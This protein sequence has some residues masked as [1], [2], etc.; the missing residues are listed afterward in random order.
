M[1][2]PMVTV[3]LPTFNRANLVE[4]SILSV[5]SQKYQD[6]ELIIVDDCSTD[7]TERMINKYL[8]SK[9]KCIKHKVNKGVSAARNTGLRNSS[10][11]KYVAFIDD[12]DEWL[13]EKL[14]KQIRLIEKNDVQLGAVGC[15][16]TDICDKEKETIIPKHRGWVFDQLLSR[17]AKGYG[18]PLLLVNRDL[19]RDMF[20]D[21]ELMCLEDNDF[22]MAIAKK[23]QVDFV[24]EPLVTVHR[25][26]YTGKHLWNSENALA[27]YQAMLKK[28]RSELNKNPQSRRFLLFL[29]SPRI[30]IFE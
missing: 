20:F 14:G 4:R 19:T 16:R 17:S 13:P 5:I 26:K 23:Y 9:I 25:G 8:S 24:P 6:W 27:G 2:N 3:I 29:Y 1:E 15:G 18:A 21:E 22:V 12:D 7:E 10:Q 11:S 28:Y 30:C